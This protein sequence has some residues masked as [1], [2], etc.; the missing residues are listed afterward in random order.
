ML[1]LQFAEKIAFTYGL[2][3]MLEENKNISY[4]LNRSYTFWEINYQFNDDQ[5]FK[6]YFEM[7]RRSFDAPCGFLWNLSKDDT[8]WRKTRSHRFVAIQFLWGI[9]RGFFVVLVNQPSAIFSL[10]FVRNC[11]RFCPQR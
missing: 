9:Q 3:A 6:M 5:F 2:M 7:N 8:K 11:G 1:I 4:F 10:N